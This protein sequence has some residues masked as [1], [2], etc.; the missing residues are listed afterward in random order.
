L[1]ASRTTMGHPY[2]NC[3]QLAA[4]S[5]RSSKSA[6][7]IQP[8]HFHQKDQGQLS[9]LSKQPTVA[10]ADDST[11]C[12]EDG[13]GNAGQ[14]STI[15][16]EGM[17]GS[18]G[19]G[20]TAPEVSLAPPTTLL[21]SMLLPHSGMHL[22]LPPAELRASLQQLSNFAGLSYAIMG[23]CSAAA[24]LATGTDATEPL[25]SIATHTHAEVVSAGG[26][27]GSELLSPVVRW[28]QTHQLSHSCY[29]LSFF[30]N[31][32]GLMSASFQSFTGCKCLTLS[33]DTCLLEIW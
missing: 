3:L 17:R 31:L 25:T 11:G 28:L 9:V 2:R 13:V 24:M 6:L 19:P 29:T 27:L 21:Q 4:G 18:R 26:G 5:F 32:Q 7:W 1:V 10:T 16:A 12:S 30:A 20:A 23:G 8:R 15:A 33:S 14:S 22:V